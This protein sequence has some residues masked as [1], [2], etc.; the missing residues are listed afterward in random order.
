[1]AENAKPRDVQAGWGVYR[2]SAYAASLEE[3]NAK[4]ARAAFNSVSPR[5]YTHYRK[6]HRYGYERYIPINVLDVETHR[7]PVWGVP[8]RSRYRSRSASLVVRIVVATGEGGLTLVGDA[9]DISDAE[10]TVALNESSTKVIPS[11]GTALE[12]LGTEITF[13]DVVGGLSRPT[14]VDIVS[15]DP[16]T[17]RLIL[18]YSFLTLEP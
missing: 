1:M 12:G 13:P 16:D 6:L 2:A 5:T 4:L 8:L 18:S 7:N 15:S 11:G 14:T 10:M 3:I 9:V 17:A